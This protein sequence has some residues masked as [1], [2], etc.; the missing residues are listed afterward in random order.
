MS[1]IL[2]KTEIT[3]TEKTAIQ[4]QITL[5]PPE[6]GRIIHHDKM[7]PKLLLCILETLQ[8]MKQELASLRASNEQMKRNF[9]RILTS[10]NA[11]RN[12]NLNL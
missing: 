12:H 5:Y 8:E 3:E 4:H 1:S 6:T 9:D 11:V 10:D 7:N 2:S